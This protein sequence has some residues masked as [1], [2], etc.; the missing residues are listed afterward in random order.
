MHDFKA[1]D[2]PTLIDMLAQH[3][4]QYTAKLTQKN[5]ELSQHEYE[6]SLIQSEL[7]YRKMTSENTSISDP[8]I[9]IVPKDQ[10]N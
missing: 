2:T 8:T 1:I 5:V 10:D 3:T 7:N 6:I 9:S 4:A